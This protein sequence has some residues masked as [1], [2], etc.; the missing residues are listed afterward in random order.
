MTKVVVSVL[1]CSLSHEA[2]NWVDTNISEQRLVGAEL[3]WYA[4]E[5]NRAAWVTVKVSKC[6]EA[7]QG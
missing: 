6:E 2:A 1:L 3:L 5:G 7:H 4:K